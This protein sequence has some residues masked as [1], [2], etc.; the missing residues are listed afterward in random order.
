MLESVPAIVAEAIAVGAVAGLSDT[1]KQAVTDAYE[2]LKALV[3][4]RVGSAGVESVEQQPA[5]AARRSVL[6][7]DLQR[8]DADSDHELLA[9]AQALLAAVRA[10]ETGA[11]AAVGV[12]LERVTAAALRI[13]H[14]ESTGTGV[15]VVGGTFDGDIE[16]GSVK[17]GKSDPQDPSSARR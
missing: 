10:H 15:R 14:V 16:I 2:K 1:A 13:Q 8:A 11:G 5:S 12:D 6:A 3:S 4:D 17:A 9:A 7:E